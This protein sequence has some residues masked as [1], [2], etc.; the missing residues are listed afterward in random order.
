ML[1]RAKPWGKAI[2]SSD[3]RLRQ[4]TVAT[5]L[6]RPVRPVAFHCPLCALNRE[7]PGPCQLQARSATKV[8]SLQ[9]AQCTAHCEKCVITLRTVHRRACPVSYT[10]RSPDSSR[11]T[12]AAAQHRRA[13]WRQNRLASAACVR[14]LYPVYSSVGGSLRFRSRASLSAPVSKRR[15]TRSLPT[16]APSAPSAAQ[17]VG[18]RRHA[19]AT[20]EL[21]GEMTGILETNRKS[22]LQHSVIG[23]AQQSRRFLEP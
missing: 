21:H 18:K 7:M 16:A 22:N 10:G 11:R 6:V 19:V 3:A 13:A 12:G 4:D 14:C 9:A 17:P 2:L 20:L 5:H 15:P 23:G 1:A 8:R